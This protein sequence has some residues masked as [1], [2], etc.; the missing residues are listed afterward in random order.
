MLKSLIVFL[1]PEIPSDFLNGF[2]VM[3]DGLK[4]NIVYIEHKLLM[5]KTCEFCFHLCSRNIWFEEN[6]IRSNNQEGKVIKIKITEKKQ[7]HNRSTQRIKY[8]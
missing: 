2:I 4:I 7:H 6:R 5:I 3:F 1:I 8:L